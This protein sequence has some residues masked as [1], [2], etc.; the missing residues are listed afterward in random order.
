MIIRS[1]K[2]N[3]FGKLKDEKIE[4]EDGLNIVY[5]ANESGKST[6]RGFIVNMLFGM[7]RSRGRSSK[8]DDYM[9][10]EPID[11][12]KNYSGSMEIEREGRTYLIRR[13]FYEGAKRDKVLILSD[14][15][16]IDTGKAAE[17]ALSDVTME[18]F[19]NTVA[20][21][22]RSDADVRILQNEINKKIMT[23][24]DDFEGA[25]VICGSIEKMSAQAKK[26]ETD[27]KSAVKVQETKLERLR[28]LIE[29]E[30]EGSDEVETEK[31]SN[32]HFDINDEN[33]DDE[34]T[35]YRNKKNSGRNG[36]IACAFTAVIAVLL[37][38]I[39][40]EYKIAFLVCAVVMVIIAAILKIKSVNE[41]S[42]SE[43]DR[44]EAVHAKKQAENIKKQ[45]AKNAEAQRS[46]RIHRLEKLYDE[47][48]A[49]PYIKKARLEMESSFLVLETMQEL[50]N[51]QERVYDRKLH[52][53]VQEL[54][55][56]ITRVPDARVIFDSEMRYSLLRNG[57]IVPE[58]QCSTGTDGL[59]RQ[60]IGIAGAELLWPDEE[61]PIILDDAF[62]NLDDERCKRMLYGLAHEKRQVIVF[63]CQKRELEFL[64][65]MQMPYEIVRW[66]GNC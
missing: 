48:A 30:K 7:K 61:L 43:A 8:T 19:T 35:F 21:S 53:K 52:E 33:G 58:W 26:A 60:L 10:Y 20:V 14:G 54:F 45:L 16:M 31:I 37:A 12:D 66:S 57:Q 55:R 4:L 39:L 13:D 42:R 65:E 32:R 15:E 41:I 56:E 24:P 51:E 62:V 34:D 49:D 50:L 17:N 59:M 28:A 36:W 46:D 23:G 2:I 63:T 22:Q 64:K 3:G 38:L 9:R 25:E 6:V 1:I 47:T 11:G 29:Y 40:N 44:K 27:Y 5:G 18:L